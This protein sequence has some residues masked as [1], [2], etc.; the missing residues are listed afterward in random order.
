MS[1][2]I[3]KEEIKKISKL[4]KIACTE[5]EFATLSENISK[6]LSYMQQLKEIDTEKVSPCDHAINTMV[7]IIRDDIPGKILPHK[8]YIESVSKNIGGMIQ[9]PAILS[10][11]TNDSTQQSG[12]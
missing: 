3:F 2:P 12:N 5:D 9:V 8:E 6:I 1:N 10:S 7:N 4:C 11:S